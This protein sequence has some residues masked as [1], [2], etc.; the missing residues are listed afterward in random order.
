LLTSAYNALDSDEKQM[1]DE[2]F[3]ENGKVFTTSH[4]HRPLDETFAHHTDDIIFFSETEQGMRD[5]LN[6]NY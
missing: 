4:T 2:M 6:N 1:V 3:I 5:F